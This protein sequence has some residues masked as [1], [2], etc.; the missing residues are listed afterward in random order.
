M[1]DKTAFHL[2]LI[3]DLIDMKKYPFK[4]LLI[5]KDLSEQEY[6]DLLQLLDHL[7]FEYKEQ[8]EQGL[9]DYTSLLIHFV[10]MLN[11]KLSPNET[12]LALQ[13]EGYYKELMDEFIFLL[14]R[15]NL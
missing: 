7:N 3:M 10:G 9:L 12:I 14:N 1:Q 13:Q 8:K 5:E 4:K 15:Y 2:Q 6:K 11:E